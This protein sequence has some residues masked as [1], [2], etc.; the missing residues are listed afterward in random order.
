LSPLLQ[1]ARAGLDEERERVRVPQSPLQHAR[2]GLDEERT[3]CALTP[4][5]TV[6]AEPQWLVQPVVVV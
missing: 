1:H 6:A 3:S 2:A 5:K 4:P